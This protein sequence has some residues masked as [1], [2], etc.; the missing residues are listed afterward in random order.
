MY[1]SPNVHTALIFLEIYLC[2]YSLLHKAI[3]STNYNTE[4]LDDY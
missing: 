1:I 4:W 2:I 3:D